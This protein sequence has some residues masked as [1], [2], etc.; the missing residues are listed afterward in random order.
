MRTRFRLFTLSTVF[1]TTL[2]MS[3]HAFAGPDKGRYG[4]WRN[5]NSHGGAAQDSD[6]QDLLKDL[7]GLIKDAE[8]ARAADPMFLR[9]LKDLT[10]RY[11]NPWPIRLLSDNFTDGDYTRSPRWTVRSGEYFVE[12]G[13]GLRSKITAGA[14]A[15]PTKATAISKKELALS[16]L[17]A[18]LNG[19]RNSTTTALA[20][21]KK[22][23]QPASISTRVQLTNAFAIT[24]RI[25]SWV[26][27]G[28]FEMGLTQG[29]PGMG[30]RLAYH[31]GAN[32]GQSHLDLLKATT[33]GQS[34]IDSS[35]L[36]PLEDKTTHTI[37]WSHN[38]RGQM[39]VKIDGTT[40]LNARDTSFRDA[41]NGVRLTSDG[42]DVIVKSITVMGTR[43]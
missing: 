8:Q 43:K 25:T 35:A 3:L 33:R 30:Y 7:N 18:V 13:Y 39:I 42:A 24:A 23:P 34:V 40:L 27:K 11:E 4:S 15:A 21:A 2:V 26:S 1:C 5:S 31:P 41:F 36:P 19:N 20:P 14:S 12:T 32:G 38:P 9:D 10:A 22:P 28:R 16:I 17:G 6:L 37:I 29:L